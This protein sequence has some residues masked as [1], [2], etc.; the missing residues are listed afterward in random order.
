LKGAIFKNKGFG[1][2]MELK[3]LQ[4]TITASSIFCTCHSSSWCHSWTELSF[5][6]Q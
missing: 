1:Y 5:G 6:C 4:Q 3:L 2:G